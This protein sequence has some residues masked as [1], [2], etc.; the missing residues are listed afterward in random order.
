MTNSEIPKPAAQEGGLTVFDLAPDYENQL[1]EIMYYLDAA[2]EL[3]NI[4]IDEVDRFREGAEHE[5]LISMKINEMCRAFGIA[6][7]EWT[8]HLQASE[9]IVDDVNLNNMLEDGDLSVLHARGT[10]LG[11]Y[12]LEHSYRSLPIEMDEDGDGAVSVTLR[13]PDGYDLMVSATGEFWTNYPVDDED[14]EGEIEI[15]ITY[16]ASISKTN[17]A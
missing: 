6:P 12:L 2:D 16:T 7:A 11:E 4:Y 13:T 8:K 15:H 5:R 1:L 9:F 10:T 14:A 17:A 3:E